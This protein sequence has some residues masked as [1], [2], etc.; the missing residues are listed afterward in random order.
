MTNNLPN[1]LNALILTDPMADLTD[2]KT[3]IMMTH[4]TVDII[5][6]TPPA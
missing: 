3:D 4:T 1:G 2:M 5:A 6:D